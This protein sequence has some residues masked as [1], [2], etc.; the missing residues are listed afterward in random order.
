VEKQTRILMIDDQPDFVETISF[1]LKSK[2][3]FVTSTTDGEEG[4][5]RVQSES[6]D[7]LFLDLHMPKISGIEILSRIRASKKDLPVILITAYPDEAILDKARELGISGLFPKDG[8]FEK[9]TDVIEVA[10][11]THRKLQQ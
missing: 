6:F 7:M 11:R 2:G 10:L 3:Y 9:L 5:A 1:W 8:S 4:L